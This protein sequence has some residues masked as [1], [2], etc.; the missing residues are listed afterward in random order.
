MPRVASNRQNVPKVTTT[1]AVL[2]TENEQ[3]GQEGTATMSMSGD[4]VLER[5]VI[6]PVTDMV[7]FKEKAATLAFMDEICTVVVADATDEQEPN[8]VQLW[9]DG[10][11]QLVPRG[12]ETPLKRKYVEVLARLKRDTFSNEKFRDAEGNESVRWPKKTAL[13]YPFHVTK[14]PNPKGPEWLKGVLAEGR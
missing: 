4:A 14:D 9:N 3:V 11:H 1:K 10:R 13:R 7:G 6:E 12:I 2:K 8:F 5:P